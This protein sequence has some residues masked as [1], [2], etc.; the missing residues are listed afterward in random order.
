MERR[1]APFVRAEIERVGAARFVVDIH[2]FWNS[3]KCFDTNGAF[4]AD[5]LKTKVWYAPE[6]APAG[7]DQVNS[8]GQRAMTLEGVTRSGR[9]ERSARSDR[10][11]RE[12]CP[13]CWMKLPATGVCETCP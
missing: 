7:A 11:P 5:V 6:V 1:H 10:V 8:W 2:G 13:T 9:S 12:S 3:V 4:V